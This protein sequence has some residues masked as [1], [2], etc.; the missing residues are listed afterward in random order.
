MDLNVKEAPYLTIV[1]TEYKLRGRETNH[2]CRLMKYM[3]LKRGLPLWSTK[4]I[5]FC[6]KL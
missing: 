5:K 6:C 3:A 4:R 2:W 1:K